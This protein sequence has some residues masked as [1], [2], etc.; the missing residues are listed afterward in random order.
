MK[1]QVNPFPT[2]GYIGADYFCDRTEETARLLN[3]LKNGQSV[4]LISVRRIGKTGLIRHVLSKMPENITGVYA[5]I[6]ATENLNGF[7]NVIA[8]AVLNAVPDNSPRGKKIWGFIKSIR[9]VFTIDPLTGF[10][11]VSIDLKHHETA[12]QIEAVL[13][14]LDALPQKTVIAIDEFQQILNYPEK[15]TDAWLRTIIQT[16]KNVVFVFSGSQQHL[17]VDLFSDPSRPFFRSTGLMRLGKLDPD[18][19]RAFV[20]R[21]FQNSGREIKDPVAKDMLDWAGNHTY[22]VQLLC[23]RVFNTGLKVISDLVWREEAGNLL[24]EQ[25]IVFINYRD[26]LT[27]PQWQLL[28][29]VAAEG[30]VYT[31]T[32]KGFI[33]KYHLG[34]PAT[35]LR[36]MKSLMKSE[37]IYSDHDNNGNLVYSVYDV[38][39]QRWIQ[40]TSF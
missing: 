40:Y 22:Y 5:D 27:L 2:T 9:P 15:N 37:M 3:D 35:V 25:E 6:L 24:K 13:K 28:K 32:S 12:P 19:Y 33:S 17:M 30:L 1:N 16:L 34:S 23:N 11:Q 39:F 29:S 7:F 26:L 8:T 38:L 20:V 18:E 31:P 36:S 14:F 10:P 21:H 4:T